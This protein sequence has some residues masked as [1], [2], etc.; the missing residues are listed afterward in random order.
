MGEAV[1]KLY[2]AA[3]F[4]PESKAKMEALVGNIRAALAARIQNVSW[5]TDATKAR[6][7]QKLSMLTVKIGYPAKWRD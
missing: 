6:A 3:Y 1:G 5:M 4:P 2:A 7:L